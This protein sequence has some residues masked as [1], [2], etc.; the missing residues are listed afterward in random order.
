MVQKG[1]LGFIFVA[2]LLLSGCS[3]E[4]I[5]IG[6]D[7]VPVYQDFPAAFEAG[8]A[9]LAEDKT[10]KAIKALIQ[11]TELDPKN[12]EAFFQLGVAL[13][14]RERMREEERRVSGNLPSDEIKKKELS[15]RETFEKAI[16]L[17]RDRVKETPTDHSSFFNLG[18]A[19]N[20][21]DRD[22]EAES[23]YREA[24]KLSPETNDYR[25]KL[26]ETLMK[27]AKWGEAVSV[28][29]RAAELDPDNFDLSEK[30]ESAELGRRRLS[31]VPSP[32]PTPETEESEEP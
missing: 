17:Y 3:P 32:T 29:R 25:I 13:A 28:L 2:V 24:L 31:F 22:S 23:A 5:E 8:N 16:A 6:S 27:L 4:P 30:I 26:G 14:E 9:F 20:R 15:S 12:P 7:D 21:L 11:A 10:E 19:L 1:M 18:R